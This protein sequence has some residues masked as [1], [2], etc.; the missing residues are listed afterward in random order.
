MTEFVLIGLPTSPH[1]VQGWIKVASMTDVPDRFSLLKSILIQRD[2]GSA[3]RPFDIEGVKYQ[4]ERVLLKLKGVDT[5]EQADA[6]RGHRIVVPAEQ[7]PP[8]EEKDTYYTFQLS[9]MS[10]MDRH[11]GLIGTLEEIYPTG[12]ND[13]YLVRA[14]D[15]KTEYFVPAIKKCILSVDVERKIMVVDREF[16]T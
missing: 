7:V 15:G 11:G 4:A 6:L 3:L 12:G 13:I 14:A 2:A 16:V 9:G 1:G 10:V 8:I 5:R